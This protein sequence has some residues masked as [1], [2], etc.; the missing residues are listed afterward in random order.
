MKVEEIGDKFVVSGEIECGTCKGT[1]LY[2]GIAERDGAAVICSR[3]NGTGK[4]NFSETFYIFKGRKERKDVERVFDNNYDC[5]ISA[6]DS[7]VNG[8]LIPFSKEGV[9]YKSWFHDGKKPAPIKSLICPL[10]HTNQSLEKENKN[11]L[12]K[13]RCRKGIYPGD[14]ICDCKF[15]YDKETCWLIYGGEFE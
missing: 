10:I 11:N 6:K 8:E 13:H 12:Y 15:F 1:G 7:I 5:F 9:S 4:I 3:C 2:V 14:R